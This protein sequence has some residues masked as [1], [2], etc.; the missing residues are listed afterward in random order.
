MIYN[1]EVVSVNGGMDILQWHKRKTKKASL[2]LAKKLS[3]KYKAKGK[4]PEGWNGQECVWVEVCNND[5]EK[6]EHYQFREGV[7]VYYSNGF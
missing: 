5:Y 7:Q 1:I 6:V 3:L 4:T 2:N